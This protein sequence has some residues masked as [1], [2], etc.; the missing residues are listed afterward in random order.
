MSTWSWKTAKSHALVFIY[1]TSCLLVPGAKA[2]NGTSGVRYVL[3]LMSMSSAPSTD[4]VELPASLSQYTVQIT[5][6]VVEGRTWYRLQIGSFD[7]ES[8]A[9]TALASVRRAYP[10]AWLTVVPAV[11]RTEGRV[12]DSSPSATSLPA[13][14]VPAEPV[15]DLYVINLAATQ[16]PLTRTDIGPV[17]TA[18]GTDLY[19]GQTVESGQTWY[20]L[21]VGPYVSESAA[22]ARLPEWRTRFPGAWLQRLPDPAALGSALPGATQ[23]PAVMAASESSSVGN[24]T[25]E[26][27]PESTAV[28]PVAAEEPQPAFY[29]VIV[30]RQDFGVTTVLRT[31]DGRVLVRGADLQSWNL[32]LPE[33]AAAYIRGEPY[34]DPAALPGYSFA[35][36][37]ATLSVGMNFDASAF[38]PSVIGG[39]PR[40][41]EPTPPEFGGF[42]NYDLFGTHTNVPGDNLTQLDGVFEIGVFSP[43]GVGTSG[44][45]GLNLV[46]VDRSPNPNERELVR[47]ESTWRRD[48]PASALTLS[49]GDSAGRAGIWGRPV[50]FGGVQWG[51]NYAIQPNFVTFPLPSVAGEAALPSTADLFIDETLRHTQQVAPGPFELIDLPV[52]TGGG[53]AR[54]VVRDVL[55]REQQ[56]S[57][58]FY[59]SNALLDEDVADYG[60]ELGFIREN[61]GRESNNYGRLVAVA[62]GRR[63][64]SDDLTIEGRAEIFQEQQTLGAGGSYV[65]PFGMLITGADAVSLRDGEVGNLVSLAV[66]RRRPRGATFS[67]RAQWATPEFTQLGLAE[68]Q[69]APRLRVNAS[70]GLARVGPGSP[71]LSYALVDERSGFRRELVSMFYSLPI[72]RHGAFILF[73]TKSLVDEHNLNVGATYVHNLGPRNTATVR[74]ENNAGAESGSLTAR[75]SLPVG[76]GFGFD[77]RVDA[78][79]QLDRQEFVGAAR[80]GTGTYRVGMSHT[81]GLVSY[82]AEADGGLAYQAGRFKLLRPVD[83]SFATVKVGAYPDIDVYLNNQQ[84]A[85]TDADGV[86]WIPD[87][88]PYQ[89][90]KVDID[91]LDLPLDAEVGLKSLELVPYF[92]SGVVAEFPVKPSRG[93]LIRIVLDSGEPLPPG[94]TVVIVGAEDRFPVARDGEVFVTGMGDVTPLQAHWREQRCEFEVRFPE[95]AG[96]LPKIGPVLCAGVTP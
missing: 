2:D 11:D 42:A 62:T 92:R 66:E 26:Q 24:T 50:R 63:G 30:N 81:P 36:D 77:A 38:L 10:D 7:T 56:I 12:V 44:I 95:D 51:K 46:S 90:N 68:G 25:A 43:W 47:L 78:F 40:S 83:R 37:E 84:V 1:I 19:V 96:P 89:P 4:D 82:R 73:A 39:R 9:R 41:P 21:R 27:A 45:A 61:L 74:Y 33:Q 15:G 86:A 22:R 31:A 52:V 70:L 13:T 79:G 18:P 85:T 29:A 55:G 75:R 91:V 49:V 34:Y 8:D 3:T 67:A 65:L 76:E 32:Q 60:F 48:W 20:R 53:E 72:A 59:A 23:Q 64:L 80:T 14:Q 88:L 87:L 93:A 71:N 54:L 5:D 57:V 6:V 16:T 28:A 17:K 69:A 94:A 58:P 35:V